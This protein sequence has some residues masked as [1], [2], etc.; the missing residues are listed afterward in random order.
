MIKECLSIA[1]AIAKISVSIATAITLLICSSTATWAEDSQAVSFRNAYLKSVTAQKDLVAAEMEKAKARQQA[2][3]EL[4]GHGQASWLEVRKQKLAVD[5]QAAIVAA[6][7]EFCEFVD[8]TSSMTIPEQWFVAGQGKLPFTELMLVQRS[9]ESGDAG[10]EKAVAENLQLQLQDR[11][12]EHQKLE[13]AFHSLSQSDPW[14]QGYM[15]RVNVAARAVDAIESDL[16]LLNLANSISPEQVDRSQNVSG[17]SNSPGLVKAMMAQAEMHARLIDHCLEMEQSRLTKLEQLASQGAASRR[18]V[19]TVARQKAELGALKQLQ[20][21]VVASLGEAG[22]ASVSGAN[23]NQWEEVRN[24]F[25]QCEAMAQGQI[26]RLEKEM[27]L[28]VLQKL[29]M[30]AVNNRFGQQSRLS[31]SLAK[32]QQAE[33]ENYRQKVKLADLKNQLADARLHSLEAQWNAGVFAISIN[34]KANKSADQL[35][36]VSAVATPGKLVESL[37]VSHVGGENTSA[38][39]SSFDAILPYV[40]FGSRLSSPTRFEGLRSDYRPIHLV[41]FSRPIS[42]SYRPV[43]RQFSGLPKSNFKP[44]GSTR[45]SSSRK[46]SRAYSPRNSKPLPTFGRAYYNGILRSEFRSSITPGQPPW[47][48]PGSPANLRYNTFQFHRGH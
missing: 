24:R 12:L 23:S 39:S 30:A 7:G 16:G 35:W 26:T 6:Y 22:T 2:L 48:F 37:L 27:L 34:G 38:A 11:L 31:S 45:Y 32:G 13:S 44:I 3:Q 20:E 42:F 36:S 21:N 17:H 29:E 33:L 15:H 46:S 43:S 4:L 5:Q 41:D 19:E 8:G 18:D 47:Y 14:K 25:S 9:F 40:N 28:E 10:A 1:T